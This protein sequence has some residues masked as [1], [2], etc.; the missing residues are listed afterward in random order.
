MMEEWIEARVEYRHKDMPF[1]AE[2]LAN[3][4]YDLDLQ[5][6]I[7][8]DP[9][10]EETDGW[11]DEDL[12]LPTQ[13]AVI[14][15]FPRD[16]ELAEKRLLLEAALEKLRQ[17]ENIFYSV[18][19]RDVSSQDW[20]ETWKVHF[21][22]QQISDRITVKPTWQP[23]DG[24][25]DEIILEMDPGMA[26]GT[27]THATTQL[28]TRLIERLL[29]KGSTVLDV[30]TGSGILLIAAAKLGAERGL[31]IDLTE[32]TVMIA[33]ENLSLNGINPEAFQVRTGDLVA[34]VDTRFDMVIANLL[35]GIVV[36]LL[37]T[38]QQVLT[39]DGIFICSGFMEMHMEQMIGKMTSLGFSVLDKETEKN[40]V[41][42]AS[43]HIR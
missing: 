18:V 22:P 5:G 19:F 10:Y 27:G 9:S 35:P 30:G 36:S 25:P 23:Y 37:D 15:Y 42:V 32:E 29:K 33:K 13:Y 6:V 24:R 31:G 16:D 38:V 40:W 34:T 12:I 21:Q 20:S 4:F 7:L 41:A 28:C 43:Q 39:P 17:N 8:E 2:I 26:F 1:A 11:A 3:V 14:G